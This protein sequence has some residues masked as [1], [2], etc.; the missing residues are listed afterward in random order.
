MKVNRGQGIVMNL[1]LGQRATSTVDEVG[2]G[3]VG[4]QCING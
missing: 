4:D 2:L 3:L 1:E